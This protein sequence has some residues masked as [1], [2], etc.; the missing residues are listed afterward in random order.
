[1]GSRLDPSVNR[2]ASN[3][4]CSDLYTGVIEG[5]LIDARFDQVEVP[6]PPLLK[7]EAYANWGRA[8]HPVAC[9]KRSS[10]SRAVD[11]AGS[12]GEKPGSGSTSSLM[13]NEDD[14]SRWAVE[15]LVRQVPRMCDLE[16]AGAGMNTAGISRPNEPVEAGRTYL[17]RRYGGLLIQARLPSRPCHH[18]VRC[19]ELDDQ[20]NT[21][22]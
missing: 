10:S 8:Q 5:D 3:R 17:L 4:A 7:P 14:S 15:K 9:R 12:Q 2:A 21:Y 22:G 6:E 19:T 18:R 13:G 11:W 16:G 1:M 20:S